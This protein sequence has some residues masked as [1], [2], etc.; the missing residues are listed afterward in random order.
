MGGSN[1]FGQYCLFKEAIIAS[2]KH[3][4]EEGQIEKKK[5]KITFKGEGG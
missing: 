1:T 2:S 5:R 4:N 3:I